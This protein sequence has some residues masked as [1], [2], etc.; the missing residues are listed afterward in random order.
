MSKVLF[1]VSLLVFSGIAIPDA[2][3]NAGNMASAE[4]TSGGNQTDTPNLDK[5]DVDK[6]VSIEQTRL[7]SVAL[8]GQ[9][10]DSV[11]TNYSLRNRYNLL[12]IRAPPVI[13]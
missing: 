7:A 12:P 4:Q 2:A 9:T 3:A 11:E 1:F 8:S 5:P 6:F 13:I 10:A